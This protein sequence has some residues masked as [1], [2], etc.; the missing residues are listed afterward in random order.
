MKKMK[1]NGNIFIHLGVMRYEGALVMSLCILHSNEYYFAVS[2]RF[3]D[4]ISRFA[5]ISVKYVLSSQLNC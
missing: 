1:N 4:S 2:M 5:E 3:L